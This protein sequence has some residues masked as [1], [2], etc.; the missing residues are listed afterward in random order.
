MWK[1]GLIVE[2]EGSYAVGLQWL[3][4]RPYQ[5]RLEEARQAS[6][7]IEELAQKKSWIEREKIALG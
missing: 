2:T 1:Q 7:T 6:A 5:E 4:I 3:L